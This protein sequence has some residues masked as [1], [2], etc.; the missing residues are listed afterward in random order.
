[1]NDRKIN[2]ITEDGPNSTRS[3]MQ[4]ALSNDTQ[5]EMAKTP[6]QL[7]LEYLEKRFELIREYVKKNPGMLEASFFSSE[8]DSD[9][10]EKMKKEIA[11]RNFQYCIENF[12]FPY[13][14]MNNC[15][16]INAD[17]VLLCNTFCKDEIDNQARTIID[18]FLFYD[19]KLFLKY[20]RIIDKK[21]ED[22]S[23]I[24]LIK[25][26]DFE[27][28]FI[29]QANIEAENF[30]KERNFED[31]VKILKIIKNLGK[32]IKFSWQGLDC[33]D[34]FLY[35]LMKQSNRTIN[36]IRHADIYRECILDKVKDMAMQYYHQGEIK[37]FLEILK[38]FGEDICG[39]GELELSM[40]NV[41]PCKRLKK[42]LEP[43]AINFLEHTKEIKAMPIRV[44]KGS[45]L[46]PTPHSAPSCNKIE[47]SIVAGNK[48]KI[49]TFKQ[50]NTEISFLAGLE[51][52]YFYLVPLNNYKLDKNVLKRFT[53]YA[54]RASKKPW[55]ISLKE[56]LKSEIDLQDKNALTDNP[57]EIYIDGVSNFVILFFVRKLRAGANMSVLEYK[58]IPPAYRFFL[59]PDPE[60][61]L[62]KDNQTE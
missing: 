39:E 1:M 43:K 6:E 19:P 16:L 8:V 52:Y 46:Q 32:D 7:Q 23:L 47:D 38:V 54:S 48:L 17:S 50:G 49:I 40:R 59:S 14:Y 5:P 28:R 3:D 26:T 24:E 9:F 21:N 34:N 10:L 61:A 56:A 53:V 13:S 36:G 12:K 11:E 55:Q 31:F 25:S 42:Y 33:M 60:K 62:E 29:A 58:K 44:I 30:F 2:T 45:L 37:D 27:K 35:Y 20:L 57:L 4:N 15:F 41:F 51:D 18:L 22:S